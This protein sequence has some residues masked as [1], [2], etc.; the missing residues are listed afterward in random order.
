LQHYLSSVSLN[1]ASLLIRNYSNDRLGSILWAGP[2]AVF[3][4]GSN[5]FGKRTVR[6]FAKYASQTRVY[7][8]GRSQDASDGV[9]AERKALNPDEQFLFLER[10]TSLMRDVD[11]IGK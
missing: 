8:I 3:V 2:V 4:G 10:A 7:I 9:K 5:G 1:K 6:Q 11:Y